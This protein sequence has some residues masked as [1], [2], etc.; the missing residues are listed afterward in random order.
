MLM[1]STIGSNQIGLTRVDY[2][3]N[4]LTDT[5]IYIALNGNRGLLDLSLFPGSHLIVRETNSINT[6]RFLLDPD[7]GILKYKQDN[8]KEQNR[9]YRINYDSTF[10]GSGF[11]SNINDQYLYTYND[12]LNAIDSFD[13]DTLANSLT[14]AKI[15]LNLSESEMI[16]LGLQKI[17]SAATTNWLAIISGL[18]DH[19]QPD[20]CKISAPKAEFTYDYDYPLLTFRDS[21]FSGVR[22]NDTVYSYT[23]NTSLS[24]FPITEDSLQVFFDTA[25]SKTLDVE[26]VISNWYGCTDTANITLNFD[27]NGISEEKPLDVKVYPNPVSDVL[28]ID[29]SKEVEGDILFEIFDLHGNKVIT[30]TFIGTS[31]R[32]TVHGLPSGMYFYTISSGSQIRRGKIVKR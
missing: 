29:F 32:S 8:L 21:S 30:E 18:K 26:L 28:H 16:M 5:S 17:G 20:P 11:V 31:L 24:P 23:W 2:F 19:W 4:I 25:V 7:L 12:N 13:L 22:Y 10:Y 1:A 6:I 27:P 3:G 9:Q 15:F 14:V